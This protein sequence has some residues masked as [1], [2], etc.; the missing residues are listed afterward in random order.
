MIKT[1]KD[2]FENPIEIKGQQMLNAEGVL[3]QSGQGQHL[4]GTCKIPEKSRNDPKKANAAPVNTV[5]LFGDAAR[6]QNSNQLQLMLE[7]IAQNVLVGTARPVLRSES[8][9][10]EATA[11]HEMITTLNPVMEIPLPESSCAN[12]APIEII[13]E[14]ISHDEEISNGNNTY[15][16]NLPFNKII[17]EDC[18]VDFDPQSVISKLYAADANQ[19]PEI[20]THISLCQ[21]KNVHCPYGRDGLAHSCSLSTARHARRAA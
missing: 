5:A 11:L 13:T 9:N 19:S 4:H 7:E 18:E 20:T 14:S 17:C 6:I 1:C 16:I 8:N 21:R 15:R 12:F 10:T 3:V 2:C